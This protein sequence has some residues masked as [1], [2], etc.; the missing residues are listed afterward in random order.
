LKA[1]GQ[2]TQAVASLRQVIAINPQNAEAYVNLG[3]TLKDLARFND[4][5]DCLNMALEIKPDFAE[6][7]LNR[8]ILYRD[9]NLAANYRADSEQAIRIKP[10]FAQAHNH[11]GVALMM[12]KHFAEA[13]A[14]FDT[15][16]SLMPEYAH[17]YVNKAH[18]KLMLGEFAEGWR[19]YE[20]R[21][22]GVIKQHRRFTQPLWLGEKDITDKILLIYPEQGLGDFIQFSRYLLLLDK[23]GG[24]LILEVPAA[25]FDLI[26][27]LP[28]NF[29][30][31]RQG[32][33]LPSFDLHCPIMSLPLAFKT[34]LDSIPNTSPY[35][36]ADT[37]KRQQWQ[38]R[39]GSKTRAR[40]GLVWSGS[41]DHS[42]NHNRSIRCDLLL[43]LLT[44]PIDFHVLQPQVSNQDAILLQSY[45]HVYLY[46]NDLNDFSDTAALAVEMDL[47]VSVDTAVAH[48]A[49]ALG[50]RLI[51]LLPFLAD[52]R[53]L[54]DRTD[55]PWYPS[56][57][58][59]RQ[60][61]S[62]DWNDVVAQLVCEV[63]KST[64]SSK[65]NN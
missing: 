25:L 33:P 19:L 12:Q 63:L 61:V 56:A 62:G 40:V 39:L 65:I 29:T 14:S 20:W 32:E 22:R 53:W 45:P 42:N 37:T 64:M 58:L 1:L 52:S 27:T 31:I 4:A 34:G 49:G 15:A 55:S 47:I 51:I 35:I 36:F 28:A 3:N 50:Q 9:L 57:R 21:W 46:T 11:L 24:Q 60:R 10:Q 5:L 30:I 23:L 2:F 48:M 17:A 26:S 6:A 41:S 43:P 59:L 16:I 8:A 54:V 38:V 7:Y 13:L 44:L 18:Y